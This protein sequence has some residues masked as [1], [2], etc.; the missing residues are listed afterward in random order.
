MR[1]HNYVLYMLRKERE[2]QLEFPFNGGKTT[3]G[4]CGSII[5]QDDAM[6]VKRHTDGEDIEEDFCGEYC[7]NEFYLERLRRADG[8]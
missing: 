6:R 5:Y 7:A 4:H 1:Y 3:C 8:Q 2:M